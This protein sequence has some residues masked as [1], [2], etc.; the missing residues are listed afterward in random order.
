M[1]SRKPPTPASY[2][3][4]PKLRYDPQVKKWVQRLL[5]DADAKPTDLNETQLAFVHQQVMQRRQEDFEPNIFQ[6]KMVETCPILAAPD[7]TDPIEDFGHIFAQPEMRAFWVAWR[8]PRAAKGPAPRYPGAKAVMTV[9]SMAGASAHADDAFALLGSAPDLQ[10]IFADLEGGS[11]ELPAYS[12]A[13]R[14]MTRLSEHDA[15]AGMPWR[16]TSRS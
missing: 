15:A 11:I 3:E 5:G 12:S 10:A 8:G 16:R 13:C 6:R 4:L 1:R 14:L 9:L 2:V 7:L